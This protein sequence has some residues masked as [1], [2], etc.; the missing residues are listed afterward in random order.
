MIDALLSWGMW[1]KDL[2]TG[3]KKLSL[4][5]L[6]QA[7]K[8]AR[9]IN[10]WLHKILPLGPEIVPEMTYSEA[11]KYFVT[12]KPPE[13]SFK[14]AAILIQPHPQGRLFLQV[15]LDAQDDLVCK[16]DGGP[17]GRRLIVK[18]FDDELQKA[19]G[20]KDLLIVE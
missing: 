17:Y 18:A 14:R 1:V 3:K 9:E 15:F 12:A 16:P 5:D 13:S 20:D 10:D 19:F 6:E 2:L 8:I 4:S 7:Q 11:M